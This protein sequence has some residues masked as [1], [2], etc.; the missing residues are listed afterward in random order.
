MSLKN[1]LLLECKCEIKFLISL[2]N[3]GSSACEQKDFFKYL[4]NL[5]V[6]IS[7]NQE[8]RCGRHEFGKN[9]LIFLD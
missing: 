9:K 7:L 8:Q 2:I 4:S 5:H 1:Y 3:F 6:L